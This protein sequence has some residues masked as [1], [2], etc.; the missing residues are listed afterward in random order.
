MNIRQQVTKMDAIVSQGAIVDAVKYFFCR[1]RQN[2]RLRK[3][4]H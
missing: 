3:W 1:R 4:W 2:I